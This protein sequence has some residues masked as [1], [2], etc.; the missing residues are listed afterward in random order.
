MRIPL[1]S[2]SNNP[3]NGQRRRLATTSSRRRCWVGKNLTKNN[4]AIPQKYRKVKKTS[5]V[6]RPI[7]N[8][9]FLG[10][11]RSFV[12]SLTTLLP[13]TE[14]GVAHHH[15]PATPTGLGLTLL[16]PSGRGNVGHYRSPLRVPSQTKKVIRLNAW[17]GITGVGKRISSFQALSHLL[18]LY[19]SLFWL[20][21]PSLV[22]CNS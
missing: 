17:R 13:R 22:L 8:T 7:A 18:S 14:A 9:C 3:Q 2:P 19:R 11:G 16:N 15:H 10:H 6:N 5:D 21:S 12:N 1:R 4:A 20:F